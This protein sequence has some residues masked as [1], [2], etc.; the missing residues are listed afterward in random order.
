VV[1]RD[2]SCCPINQCIGVCVIMLVKCVN[3]GFDLH[4][5][6]DKLYQLTK[7]RVYIAFISNRFC[8]YIIVDDFGHASRFGYPRKRF[9]I[10]E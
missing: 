2:S 8:T 7:D 10:Y 1:V 4:S 9:I 6:T 5:A 3:D